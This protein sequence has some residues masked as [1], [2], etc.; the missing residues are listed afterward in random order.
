MSVN[1]TLTLSILDLSH[2]ETALEAY[3]EE[4]IDTRMHWDDENVT[5]EERAEIDVIVEEGNALLERI[6]AALN[7]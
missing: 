7:D 6:R 2:I 1:R 3:V 4:A 5:P